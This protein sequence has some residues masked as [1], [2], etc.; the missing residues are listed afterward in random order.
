MKPI[1]RIDRR[2]GPGRFF[3]FAE[4]NRRCRAYQRCC[5]SRSGDGRGIAASVLT[6]IG[7]HADRYQLKG[8]NI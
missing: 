1:K 8:R 5:D 6:A 2:A 4:N 3:Y 7:D